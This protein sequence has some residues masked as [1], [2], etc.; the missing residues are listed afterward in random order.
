MVTWHTKTG[1]LTWIAGLAFGVIRMYWGLSCGVKRSLRDMCDEVEQASLGQLL[2]TSKFNASTGGTINPARAVKLFFNDDAPV[3]FP[4]NEDDEKRLLA[5]CEPATFGRDDQD[6]L[7]PEYRKAVKLD[8]DQFATNFEADLLQSDAVG[9]IKQALCLRQ[10]V[11]VV[12][13]LDKLNCYR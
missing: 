2:R 6:V 11:K 12:L 9:N 10:D 7:D 5:K 8:G 3:T 4:L 13:K 1:E